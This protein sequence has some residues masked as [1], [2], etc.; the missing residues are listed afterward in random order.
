MI[1]FRDEIM[2]YVNTNNVAKDMDQWT[3]VGHIHE[4]NI[5]L[6]SVCPCSVAKTTNYK[7]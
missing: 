3:L 5:V 2:I 4:A 1:F 6:C 7:L